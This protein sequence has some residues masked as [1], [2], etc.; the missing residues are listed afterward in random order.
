MLGRTRWGR[1]HHG[2]K[3]E[4]KMASSHAGTCPR[5]LL[6]GLVHSSVLTVN[7][8]PKHHSQTIFSFV[9]TELK[10]TLPCLALQEVMK[11][12]GTFDIMFWKVCASKSCDHKDTAW[13]WIAGMNNK[14]ITKVGQERF[15]ITRDGALEIHQVNM[16]D[17][18]Q[19]MCTV[20]TI[21]HASPGVH[22]TTLVVIGKGSFKLCLALS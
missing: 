19:Y 2:G 20:K 10:V 6:Q 14:G 3:P 8:S 4:A 1:T 13:D 21:N 22:H 18:G 16:S 9:A 11:K 7:P 15:N 5:D 17:S 12:D